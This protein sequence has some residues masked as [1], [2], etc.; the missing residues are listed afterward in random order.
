MGQI[1][2]EKTTKIVGELQSIFP[3]GY[4]VDCRQDTYTQDYIIW[5]TAGDAVQPFR[6][7]LEEYREDDWKGNIRHALSQIETAG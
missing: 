1:V 6:I 7:T 4:E 2:S 5:I 3:A